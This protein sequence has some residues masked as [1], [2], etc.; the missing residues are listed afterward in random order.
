V[1][2]AQLTGAAGDGEALGRRL[3]QMLLER[4]GAALLGRRSHEVSL[5]PPFA[6]YR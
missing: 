1:I 5:Q 2:R 3:A 6:P 4:G